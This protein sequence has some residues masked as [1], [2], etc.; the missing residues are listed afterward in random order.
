MQEV[1]A[2]VHKGRRELTEQ[3]DAERG[4]DDEVQIIGEVRGGQRSVVGDVTGGEVS[5]QG[6]GVGPAGVGVADSTGGVVVGES[7]VRVGEAVAAEVSVIT[8]VSEVDSRMRRKG[9]VRTGRASIVRS[10]DETVELVDALVRQEEE[11]D[12]QDQVDY[13]EVYLEGYVAAVLS[14]QSRV[15]NFDA[16]YQSH[17]TPPTSCL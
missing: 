15:A 9:G 3:M 10:L 11:Q 5:G 6:L 1:R 2:A 12:L 4:E 17:D 8:Y 13:L 14:H 16:W 7:G